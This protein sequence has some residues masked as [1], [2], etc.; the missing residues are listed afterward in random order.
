MS[1][2][3]ASPFHKPSP[4]D[5]PRPVHPLSP[6]ETDSEAASL[7]TPGASSS[8]PMMLGVVEPDLTP[9]Q[10]ANQESPSARFKRVS[11]LAY[12]H[13]SAIRETRERSIQRNSKSLVVVVPPEGITQQHGQL[14]HTLSSGPRAKLA[15]GILMPLFPTVSAMNCSAVTLN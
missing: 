1:R 5:F 3:T 8:R 7:Y 4:Y 14:G 13:N 11:T 12:N 9:S 6:P 2:L 15:Q 10:Q